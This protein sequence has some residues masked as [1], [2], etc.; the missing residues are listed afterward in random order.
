MSL[1]EEDKVK[2]AGGFLVQVAN[3]EEIARLKRIKKSISVSD[4]D[5]IEAILSV[6]LSVFL[7]ESVSNVT[8]AMNALWTLLPAFSSDLQEM[9]RKTTGQKSLINSADNTARWKRPG[10]L[11]SATNLNTPFM[12]GNVGPNH[13]V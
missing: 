13:A 5:H 8:V 7:E 9:K 11:I 10:R 12:I 1:D 3:K 2:V 4:E 6:R